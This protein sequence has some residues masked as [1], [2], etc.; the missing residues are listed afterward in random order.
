MFSMKAAFE[1]DSVVDINLAVIHMMKYGGFDKEY[2]VDTYKIATD[3]FYRDQLTK[4]KTKNPLSLILKE[5]YVSDVLYQD[6]LESDELPFFYVPN[7]VMGLFRVLAQGDYAEPVIVCKNNME[8]TYIQSLG[9]K[10]EIIR[11]YEYKVDMKGYGVYYKADIRNFTKRLDNPKGKALKVLRFRWNMEDK[12][13]LEMP[14]M[15][16]ALKYVDLN[17]FYFVDP[18]VIPKAVD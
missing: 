5:K 14:L 10:D 1:F 7:S 16:E 3:Y 4:I 18:Y 12:E 15:K 17:K 2:L 6:I 9:I 11:L 8:R 13:G